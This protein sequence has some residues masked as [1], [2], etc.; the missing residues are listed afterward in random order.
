M[1][2]SCK[3]PPSEY[4]PGNLFW[5]FNVNQPVRL[6]IKHTQNICAVLLVSWWERIAYDSACYTSVVQI[7]ALVSDHKK[8]PPLIYH[9][10]RTILQY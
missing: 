8:Q 3:I 4:S 2:D 6:A 5:F 9:K 7:L 1:E 10:Y